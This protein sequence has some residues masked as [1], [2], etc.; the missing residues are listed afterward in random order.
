MPVEKNIKLIVQPRLSPRNYLHEYYAYVTDEIGK[1]G[2]LAEGGGVSLNKEVAKMKAIGEAIER[3]CGRY[4]NKPLI[5]KRLRDI[6]DKSLHPQKVIYFRRNQ[7][8]KGFLYNRFR[9]SLPINWV[10]GFSLTRK[11]S[12][13]I[14]AFAVYLGYNRLIK[15][16]PAFTV[17]TS[18][19]L[20]SGKNLKRAT[21]GSIFEL[22]ERDALMI[23]WYAKKT[24]PRLDLQRGSLPE[25]RYLHSKIVEEGYCPEVCVTTVDIPA[26]SVVAII[27]DSRRKLPYASFGAA[28]DFNI[29]KAALKALEEALLVREVLETLNKQKNIK[30]N[31]PSLVN[32]FLDHATL[33]A[34]PKYKKAWDF[35]LDGPV[36]SYKE[37]ERSYGFPKS[38]KLLDLR[39]IIEIFKK[40]KM[41][42]IRVNLT[43]NVVKDTSFK[44]VKVIIPELQPIDV[45]YKAR[46]L[47]GK[48]LYKFVKDSKD[49][50]QYPHPIG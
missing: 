9:S 23:T 13:L 14:P 30:I 20:A 40:K 35:L 42:I 24:I 6:K 3:Y 32:A 43:N 8:R 34:H 46:F 25:L 22:I 45:S 4:I 10:K 7:Y 48:R 28:A 2:N 37:I 15:D 33:Y 1:E 49:I 50:N 21:I 27:Y 5:K 39:N 18:N 36:H 41:E 38:K 17:T 11:K 47:G 26:P 29:E 12:L 44:V 31:S 16:E 19:G